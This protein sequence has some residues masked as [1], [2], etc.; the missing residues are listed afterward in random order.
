M[1]GRIYIINGSGGCGKDTFVNLYSK[2]RKVT[3][4]DSVALVKKAAVALGWNGVKDEKSRKLLAEIK[5]LSI[6]YNNGPFEY[7][8]Q[9]IS[10]TPDTSD[11]FIHVREPEEIDKLRKEY[12]CKTI[13]IV[14]DKVLK[15]TSNESDAGVNDY[16]YDFTI[17]NKMDNDFE[18]IVRHFIELENEKAKEVQSVYE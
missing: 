16:D 17:T 15:I 18:V 1:P 14:N 6:E 4:I 2:Y 13:L 3:N 10:E 8:K 7:I 11:I 5:R 9:R 12:N